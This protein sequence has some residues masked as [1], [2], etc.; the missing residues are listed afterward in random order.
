[1]SAPPPQTVI[2]IRF[3]AMGDIL[4][5]TPAVDALKKALPQARLIYVTKAQFLPLLAHNP[6]LHAQIGIHPGES[7]LHL[8]R[9]IQAYKPD[10]ILD[11]HGKPR[12][13]ILRAWVG[14]PRVV[15]WTKRRWQDTLPVKMLLR[16]YRADMRLSDRFHV[17]AEHVVGSSLPKGRLQHFVSPE[18]RVRA[19]DV[20]EQA[21][22]DL[23]RPL[24]GMSPG[25]HWKTKRWP[26][27]HFR[28]LAR[29]MVQSGVQVMVTGSAAEASLGQTIAEAGSHV[30]DLSG[31]LDIPL[32]GGAISLCSAFV[33]NDSGPMHMAR[34]LGVPTLAIFGSTDPSQFDFHGHAVL[35]AGVECSPCS[36]FGLAECPRGHFECMRRLTAED[37][38]VA[39]APLLAGPP[40][41]LLSA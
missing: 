16:T 13:A 8:V 10:V 15:A 17:A 24:V 3:S 1:M 19:R 28:D 14:A 6:H 29:K 37:A 27:E 9:S 7:F 34:G 26:V 23:G 35:F 20:M 31:R 25:A 39:L 40:R 5:T 21:G 12:S 36:F 2:I 11:L 18:D 41:P 32:L 22:V 4:L 30:K 33:A 38:F